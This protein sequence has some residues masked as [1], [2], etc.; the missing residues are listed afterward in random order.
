MSLSSSKAS[1]N[2]NAQEQLDYLIKS[3]EKL[4]GYAEFIHSK[5]PLLHITPYEIID[6]L[7]QN[8]SFEDLEYIIEDIK[9]IRYIHD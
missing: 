8:N 9:N 6:F 7:S 2:E 1:V 3:K 4:D 5:L